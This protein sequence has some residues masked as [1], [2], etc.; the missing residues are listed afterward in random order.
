V[1]S[2]DAGISFTKTDEIA[3]SGQISP[4][5]NWKQLD[6]KQ[7]VAIPRIIFGPSVSKRK[8]YARKSASVSSDETAVNEDTPADTVDSATAGDVPLNN[9]DKLAPLEQ[10]LVSEDTA[11]MAGLT[12]VQLN[13]PDLPQLGLPLTESPIS[14][15]SSRRSSVSESLTAVCESLTKVSK[16]SAA[17][18]KS[19]D[20]ASSCLA[21]SS[22]SITEFLLEIG[23]LA[24][25]ETSLEVPEL[26]QAVSLFTKPPP[27]TDPS[28]QAPVSQPLIDI[29][30][31]TEGLAS[32]E[33]ILDPEAGAAVN[34]VTWADDPLPTLSPPFRQATCPRI[35]MN[36]LSQSRTWSLQICQLRRRCSWP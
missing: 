2:N 24:Q 1:E 16:S 22:V 13:D 25:P 6:V 34:T 31:D 10:S 28:T 9:I 14:E 12:E 32:P 3:S 5:L 30:D 20:V 17:V 11:T 29:S 19:L 8:Q 35:Y 15:P 23:E 26:S 7:K 33:H 4:K 18:S 36:L 27:P 21:A